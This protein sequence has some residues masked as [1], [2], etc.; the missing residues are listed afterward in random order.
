[1]ALLN[2]TRGARRRR[3]ILA[4]VL[5]LIAA[6]LSA[7]P[8]QAVVRKIEFEGSSTTIGLQPR[9]TVMFAPEA[10]YWTFDNPE[11]HPVMHSSAVYAIYWDPFYLYHGDWEHLI[12]TFLQSAG[13]ESGSLAQVFSVNEQYTDKS[14]ARAAYKMTFRG[15]YTDTDSYP[16]SACV[17]PDLANSEGHE[18][19]KADN[20]ACLTDKQLREELKAFI[21]RNKLKTG[22]GTIFYLLTPP[23]V[24]VCGDGGGTSGHCSDFSWRKNL[25][26]AE[27]EPNEESYQHSFCS[28]HGAITSGEVEGNEATILYAAVPWTAGGA[29]DPHLF[30]RTRAFDCQDGGLDPT[31][32]KFSGEPEVRRHQEEPNQLGKEVV[33]PDGGFDTGLGDLIVNQV[34]V[35]EQNTV[36][37]PL[38]D[39]WQDKAGNEATDECRNDFALT[40]GGSSQEEEER[41]FAGTLY[42]QSMAGNHYYLNDGLSMAAFKQGYP[43][44]GCIPGTRLEPQFTVP[45]AVESGDIVGFDASE[46]DITLDAG[47]GYGAGAPYVTYPTYTWDF[48]DGTKTTSVYP[49]G[50]AQVDE[51]SAFHA[52][53]YGGTYTVTLTVTDVGGNTASTS[54]QVTVSGPPPPSP[55]PPASTTPAGAAQATVTTSGSPKTVKQKPAPTVFA[56]IASHS[57]PTVLHEGLIVHYTVNEQVAGN[58]EVMIATSTA[59]RLHIHGS[60]AK[61]LPRGYPRQTVIGTA[62]LVTTRRG[63]GTL[64]IELSPAAKHALSTM[65]RLKVTMRIVVRNAARQH[66]KSKTLISSFDLKG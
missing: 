24:T 11:G 55:A 64:Q 5:A 19:A 23:G 43:G 58:V 17:D 21:V 48:G 3:S 7:S 39:A 27:E 46:S 51:P 57:L 53:I 29:G 45:N 6:V 18:A 20:V 35:E 49:P 62:V 40:L 34:A 52:Y 50:A 16:G 60:A 8:A 14:N 59:K 38:L 10:P 65:S 13:A 37:D 12:D 25:A 63:H 32:K 22:M 36:T 66:P 33:G 41:T 26:T 47:Q 42:N 15:A 44:V 56:H 28:Y 54:R 9:S 2:P 61:H 4:G 31:G 1:M 30:E